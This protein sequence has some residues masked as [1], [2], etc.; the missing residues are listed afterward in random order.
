[1]KAILFDFIGTTVAERDSGIINNCFAK[2]F[3]DHKITADIEFL[4]QHRGKDKKIIIAE[5]LKSQHLPISFGQ[6]IYSSFQGHVENNL[7]NFHENEGAREIFSYLRDKSIKIGLGTGLTRNLFEKIFFHLNWGD[8]PFDYIGIAN[9]I[10]RGRPYPDMIFDMMAKLKISE[11]KEI[12]KIGDTIADI[13]E[14]KNAKV[15][16]AVLLSGTQSEKDLIDQEPEF[17][18]NKLL[19]IKNCI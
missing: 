12:L 14:G 10:G 16:T 18:L 3:K 2:A 11:T 19:D 6:R 8:I 17:V 4:K 13:Q 15:L 1:M 5:V 7:D 9:E